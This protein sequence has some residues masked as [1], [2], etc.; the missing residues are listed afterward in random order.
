MSRRSTCG[1]VTFLISITR[2]S[3]AV[4]DCCILRRRD[5]WSATIFWQ[6]DSVE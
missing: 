6:I 1:S 2:T 3:S 4:I 5:S